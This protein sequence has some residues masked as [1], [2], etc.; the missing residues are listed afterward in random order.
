[1][2]KL[3]QLKDETGELSSAD[4]KRYRALK[5]QCERDLLQ[6]ADVICCTAVGAG[7]PR[8]AKMQFRSVLIDESTQATEPECMIPIVL[9]CRQVGGA[10]NVLCY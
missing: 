7:D 2:A 6:S 10:L 3:Q 5:K 4:E 8:L 1:L 9:G